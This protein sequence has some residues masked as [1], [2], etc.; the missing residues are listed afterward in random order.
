MRSQVTVVVVALLSAV[1]WF[2]WLGWDHTYQIDPATH[3]A[4]GPYET[5][6]GVGSGIT[7]I[8]V[9]LIAAGFAAPRDIAFSSALGYAF[10]WGWTS[11]PGDESG[12]SGVGLVMV[13]IGVFAGTIVAASMADAVWKV[14]RKGQPA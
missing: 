3:I 4:S 2:A 11:I 12:M 9:V 13:L 1:A 10:A 6:Q 14:A 8:V 5:W 7:V